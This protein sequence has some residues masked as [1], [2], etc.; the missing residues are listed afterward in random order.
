MG[1]MAFEMTDQIRR[2]LTDDTLVW[3]TTVSPKGRPAPR[4]VWFMW[5][6]EYCLIYSQPEAAK[7]R[8]IAAND[9]VTVNFNSDDLGGDAVVLAG[10]AELAPDAPAPEALPGLLEKYAELLA[11][12]NMSPERFTSTYNVAIRVTVD[13]AWVIP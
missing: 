3:L 2:R 1:H 4:V 12:I 7:L 8:H 13:G 9:R 5:T 11:A 10:R 6:D